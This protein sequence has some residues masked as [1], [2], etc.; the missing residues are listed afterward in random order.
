MKY[1]KKET[2]GYSI[3]MCDFNIKYE[4]II[5]EKVFTCLEKYNLFPPTKICGKKYRMVKYDNSMRDYII[6]SYS[7]KNVLGTAYEIYDS[8]DPEMNMFFNWSYTFYKDSSV[9]TQQ[10]K[11]KPWNVLYIN[12]THP[13]AHRIIQEQLL[14]MVIELIEII[15]PFHVDIDDVS[16]AVKLSTK[17][18]S[19]T[20]FI[21]DK[22]KHIYWG[23][24]WSYSQYS[25][26]DISKLYNLPLH[27]VTAV[28]DGVFFTLSQ[29][30]EEYASKEA[31]H[32][33]KAVMKLLK[34]KKENSILQWKIR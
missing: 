8:F 30:M 33:R 32:N 9:N 25:S 2:P 21:P 12:M 4:N 6:Q 14:N 16:N 22:I 18:H 10:V 26:Y 17:K 29:N 3:T 5:S 24:Y 7:K 13:F 23:N 20:P 28:N 19:T 34:I 31:I 11:F 15:H 27:H 1:D